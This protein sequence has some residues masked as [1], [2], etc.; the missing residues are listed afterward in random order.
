[1]IMRSV[2]TG[3]II[4][5]KEGFI[6]LRKW[7][8]EHADTVKKVIQTVLSFIERMSNFISSTFSRFGMIFSRL[9]DWWNTLDDS[10][11]KLILSVIGLAAAFKLLNLGWLLSPI[12]AVVAAVAGLFLI[13]DDLMTYLEGG[14]SLIDWGPW[15]DDIMVAAAVVQ[16]LWDKL[17]EFAAWVWERLDFTEI[18]EGIKT[19]LA[20]VRE[21]FLGAF[22]ILKGLFSGD[23]SEV[24]AGLEKFWN[25]IITF[26]EGQAQ[27]LL[28]VIK[29]VLGLIGEAFGIDLSGLIGVVENIFGTL[30]ETARTAIEPITDVI[31]GIVNTIVAL[32][33]GDFS[34]A[35][36]AAGNVVRSAFSAIEAVV[37]GTLDVIKELVNWILSGLGIDAT[38]AFETLK[39]VVG[40][41]FDAIDKAIEIVIGTVK[42]LVDWAVKAV[43]K[44][45]EFFGFKSQ[46]DE[47]VGAYKEEEAGRSAERNLSDEDVE[48]FSNAMDNRDDDHNKRGMEDLKKTSPG[49]YAAV[50]EY[51]KKQGKPV[52]QEDPQTEATSP[53][54][55]VPK[56]QTGGQPKRQTPQAAP[57]QSPDSSNV[58]VEKPLLNAKNVDVES[59]P[60]I[61]EATKAGKVETKTTNI[62]QNN[63]VN[64][65]VKITVE[66]SG[67]PEEVADRVGAR[68]DDATRYTPPVVSS[69]TGTR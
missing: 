20:G 35:F 47:D 42:T 43:D 64:N 61:S 34:G 3:F 18:W 22:G 37:L 67:D 59:P 60:L 50:V 12:G 69:I 48:R 54:T 19:Q 4:K 8:I 41:V 25:G 53:A 62:Q 17:K 38:A 55:G 26:F 2:M 24:E 9:V 11:Q 28:G 15:V 68:Q 31:G 23:M 39:N 52:P 5:M 1:M 14:E 63:N 13:W 65:D 10:T 33:N 27:A 16:E 21:A 49:D 56:T 32:L 30:V 51:R 66:G 58:D 46:A 40:V 44:I 57:T 36:E 29:N 7:L 45:K 6:A